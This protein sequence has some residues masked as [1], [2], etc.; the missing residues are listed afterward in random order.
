MRSASHVAFS[1]AALAATAE[2][3]DPVAG[4]LRMR[5]ETSAWLAV[6]AGEEGAWWLDGDSVQ[7][8]PAF[9]VE[10]VDTVGAGDVFHGALAL[11]LGE[12]QDEA[13]AIRFAAAAAAVKCTKPGGRAGVPTRP[14]VEAL[15]ERIE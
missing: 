7:H 3:N 8:V 15:L 10:V 6:T 12:G 2:T 13:S 5:A 11:G 9:A 1:Q 4:L 14:E